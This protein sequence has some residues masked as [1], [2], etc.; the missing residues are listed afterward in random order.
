MKVQGSKFKVFNPE[1][2]R[3]KG[4]MLSAFTLVELLV[5]IAV[6][7]ILAAL[8]LPALTNAKERAKRAKCLSNVRQLGIASLSYAGDNR[9]RLPVLDASTA[10][11]DIAGLTALNFVRQYCP[12]RDVFYDPGN[13]AQNDDRLWT[14][15]L[16]GLSASPYGKIIGYAVTFPGAGGIR[17]GDVNLLSYTQPV[18]VGAV[19]LPAPSSSDRV[20]IAGVVVSDFGQTNNDAVSRAGYKY[21]DILLVQGAAGGQD[22]DGD[23]HPFTVTIYAR[24]SHLQGKMP[25]GDNVAMLDGSARWRK[26]APMMSRTSSGLTFWW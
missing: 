19:T 11:W 12:S 21:Y 24:S 1:S 18:Q 4:S 8:L 22:G 3:G 23:T 13:P 25:A 7:G 9:D 6:I 15:A 17:P 20:L 10:L 14:P 5:V 26:F 2:F 16:G